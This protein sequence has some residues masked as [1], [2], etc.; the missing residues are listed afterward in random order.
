M[1]AV[2]EITRFLEL[3][4]E[5]LKKGNEIER[6]SSHR[7]ECHRYS[8]CSRDVCVTGSPARFSDNM[9]PDSNESMTNWQSKQSHFHKWSHCFSES[10]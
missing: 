9:L 10:K 6:M 5:V 1:F 4:K 8:N 7:L 3:K 2:R